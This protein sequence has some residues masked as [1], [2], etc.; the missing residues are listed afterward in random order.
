MS[1][2]AFD[3]LFTRNV[4][5]IL[6]HIFLYLDY[7]SYKTCLGVCNDWLDL[8]SCESN[9]IKAKA[10]FKSKILRDQENLWHGAVTGDFEEVKRLLSTS[11]LDIECEQNG[12]FTTPL[13]QASKWGHKDL[14]Q[15]LL[16]RGADPNNAGRCGDT[17]LVV[18]AID[19]K[20]DIIK[21]LLDRG[22]DP[23]TRIIGGFTPLQGAS[24][25]GHKNVVKLLLDN[26]ANPNISD[27]FGNTPQSL[28]LRYHHKD[29]AN[30]LGGW[31][32]G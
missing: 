27:V 14:V 22:A 18:A 11:L 12:I 19:G 8:L 17:P 20:N 32:E 30:I 1:F 9:V 16:D 26:G 6:E 28:A 23:N 7:E 5:H 4:P 29:T 21:L 24:E 3:I 10:E 2:C 31:M 15:L 13:Y 25:Y